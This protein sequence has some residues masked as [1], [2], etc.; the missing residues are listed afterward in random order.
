MVAKDGEVLSTDNDGPDSD[1]I[2]VIGGPDPRVIAVDEDDSDEQEELY[3]VIA[4]HATFELDGASLDAPAGTFVRVNPGVRRTAFAREA[5][6]TVLALGAT[7]GKA[8]AASGWEVWG[9]LAPL[10]NAGRYEEAAQ[11][12]RALLEGDPPYSELYYNVA[13]CEARAGQT[14]EAIAHLRRAI[15][16]Y[17]PLRAYAREDSDLAAIR[18]EP[19]FQELIHWSGMRP[20]RS[21]SMIAITKPMMRNPSRIAVPFAAAMSSARKDVFAP[22]TTIAASSVGV[23][24]PTLY[25]AMSM[26]NHGTAVNVVRRMRSRRNSRG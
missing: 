20:T 18:D 26:R 4:G 14:A 21:T 16:L 9:P 23:K 24:I 3:F 19:V 8:Y 17:E 11:R 2:E 12:G 7:P 13:C 10:Y 22:L 25:V 1:G 15:E 6:T 5:E